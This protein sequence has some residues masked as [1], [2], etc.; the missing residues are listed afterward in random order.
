MLHWCFSKSPLN[1]A[2]GPSQSKLDI[3]NRLYPLTVGAAIRFSGGLTVP[4]RRRIANPG[5]KETRMASEVDRHPR[6]HT[7]Q[8]QT[9]LQETIDHLRE[10]ID[11]F[12]PVSSRFLKSRIA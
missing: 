8:M 6:H 4:D 10:D 2:S 3:G 12:R 5:T 11:C 1:F 7:Q 9:R